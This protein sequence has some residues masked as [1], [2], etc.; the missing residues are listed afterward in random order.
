LGPD[1][2]YDSIGDWRNGR[3]LARFLDRLAS[4]NNLT[5]T[6]LYVLNPGDNEVS[7]P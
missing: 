2:G 7:P 3:P 5:R 6:I 1:T 4:E